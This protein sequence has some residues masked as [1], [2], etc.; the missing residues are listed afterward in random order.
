MIKYEWE[1]IATEK[2]IKDSYNGFNF[3]YSAETG[4]LTITMID[5]AGNVTTKTVTIFS[6]TDKYVTSVV[7]EETSKQFIFTF[8]NGDTITCPFSV[9]LDDYPTNNQVDEKINESSGAVKEY[10]DNAIANL[11]ATGVGGNGKYIKA[12]SE[13][14]GVIFAIEETMDITPTNGSDKAITSGGVK[15]YVDETLENYAKKDG[16]YETFG[17]AREAGIAKNLQN[18]E[19][20][21]LDPDVTTSGGT[22]YADQPFTQRAT[23]MTMKAYLDNELITV[24]SG[25][26]QW[27]KEQAFSIVRNQLA[28]NL[29]NFGTLGGATKS[30]SEGVLTVNTI[31]NDD[32]SGVTS[33]EMSLK[34]GH[35]YLRII[36]FKG[37]QEVKYMFNSEFVTHYATGNW[38]FLSNIFTQAND[39]KRALV[40]Q[41]TVESTFQVR[42]CRYIDLTQWFAS[43]PEIATALNG[44]AGVKWFLQNYPEALTL[45]YDEGTIVDTEDYEYQTTGVNLWDE[46]WEV[47][48]IAADT[49]QNVN[50]SSA[51]RSKNYIEVF[52]NTE[53]Y[54]K[55]PSTMTVLQ[56]DANKNFLGQATNFYGSNNFKKLEPNCCFIRFKLVS[57]YGTTYKNDI[58]ICN[59]FTETSVEQTYHKY[60]IFKDRVSWAFT[61]TGKG[62]SA[63]S[64]A[65]T[66]DYVNKKNIEKV[67]QVD[68]GTLDWQRIQQGNFYRFA[69]SISDIF[70][71]STYA[72]RLLKCLCSKYLPNR[73][74]YEAYDNL[75][76]KC[77][78]HVSNFF[79][80]R[81]DSYN[82]AAA[83][84]AAM[85]GVILNYELATYNE[86]DME[87]DELDTNI[88]E[89]DY[90]VERKVPVS[91]NMFSGSATTIFYQDNPLRQIYNNKSSID[92][93]QKEVATKQDVMQDLSEGITNNANLTVQTLKAYRIGNIVSLSIRAL[94]E[95]GSEIPA[96]KILF[97]LPNGA[98]PIMFTNAIGLVAN[99]IKEINISYEGNIS[100]PNAL[101]NIK[102]IMLY[103]TYAVA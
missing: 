56:Y 64:V 68:L 51:I 31:A 76:D 66:K 45:G 82:D 84:K 77:W 20:K 11:T 36:E 3:D 10:I 30:Y 75:L 62:K 74:G 21:L 33:N 94:N 86:T 61:S 67:G 28:P 29:N 97:T 40:I 103:I 9:N 91:G 79:T 2:D 4:L 44:D 25:Y 43:K 34:A 50:S 18:D 41:A 19:G 37:T 1:K 60:E 17:Y 15:K 85:S 54:F 78:L 96:S 65:D 99:E 42:N 73:T 53:Y 57:D 95:T 49:G 48:E 39:A 83:F 58:Q 70:I 92:N 8:N 22:V 12:I 102:W 5:K 80:I 32:S 52:G 13:A 63:G 24:G 59:H 27:K 88:P 72:D 87:G 38:E 14:N 46:E 55:T 100:T 90:G 81:D 6:D 7:Y 93:L 71:P 47:G 35:K 26:E 69:A 89:N 23:A 16:Y 98:I 101:P